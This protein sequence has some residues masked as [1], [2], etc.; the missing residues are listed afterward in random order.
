M[1]LQP[2]FVWTQLLEFHNFHSYTS[3]ETPSGHWFRK[4]QYATSLL[5]H[6]KIWEILYN[7]CSRNAALKFHFHFHCECGKWIHNI[8]QELTKLPISKGINVKIEEPFSLHYILFTFY[9]VHY[10]L[11]TSCWEFSRCGLL[12]PRTEQRTTEFFKSSRKDWNQ[13]DC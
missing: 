13:A 6:L 1:H 9:I 12:L 4:Y 3:V 5:S 2:L 10:I 11:Y 7:W 8:Q